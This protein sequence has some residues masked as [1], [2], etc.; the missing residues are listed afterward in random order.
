MD[1]MMLADPPQQLLLAA[2]AIETAASKI[3]AG[4]LPLLAFVDSETERVLQESA[5]L[6][7]RCVIM[8]GA[9]KN[10]IG[11]LNEQRSPHLLIVDISGADMPLSR[12]Q[13]LADVCE[14]GTNVV[15]LGDQNDVSLYRDLVEIGV[16]NYI[17]KPLTRELLVKALAPRSNA[18]EV[19]RATT[20][21]GKIVS[22]C[23]ARGGV[24]TT[25]LATN[26]A[27]HLANRQ[28]RRVALVDLDLQHGDCA[29]LLNTGMI[30]GFRDAL[31][32]PLRLDHLLLN[33]I[34]AKASERLFVLGS[35]EP[36]DDN[37][38]INTA[39]IDTLF[40]ALRSQ[41]HYIV[42][43]VPRISTPAYRRALEMADRRVFV[44]DQTMRSMRDAVRLA[45][46]SNDEDG[47]PDHRNVFVVN[48]LGEAGGNALS[49]KDIRGVLQVKPVSLIPFLPKLVMPAAH[50]GEIAASKRGKFANAVAT[51]ALEISGRQQRRRW[52]SRRAK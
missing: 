33:R 8:R 11:Y 22:F 12:I 35:E 30:A 49:L 21:L 34:M 27:W 36:L 31:A 29:L 47:S 6:I 18:A 2:P 26:L 45:N 3:P 40:S 1:T 14:P 13:E 7:G 24:G 17:V 42:V 28:S 4:R 19:G 10:A 9:I 48:R 5:A 20:K 50:Y 23:G 52:W 16:S 51:L 32:N 37:V 44:V 38:Q 25:T 46:L 39:A 15:A 43:D 41:F